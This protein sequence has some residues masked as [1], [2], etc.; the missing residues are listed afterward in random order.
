[1][2]TSWGRGMLAVSLDGYNEG[3][4]VPQKVGEGTGTRMGKDT[5]QAKTF[6]VQLSLFFK[7][8]FIG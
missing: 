1:M 3:A 7:N 5:W 2:P 8:I 6:N 4:T